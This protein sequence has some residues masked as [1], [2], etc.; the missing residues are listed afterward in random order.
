MCCL[1]EQCS[2]VESCHHIVKFFLLSGTR[3]TQVECNLFTVLM[4][5]ESVQRHT[6]FWETML[7]FRNVPNWTR[8]SRSCWCWNCEI[9]FFLLPARH[10]PL[11]S[12]LHQ[13][14]SCVSKHLRFQDKHRCVLFLKSS[15]SQVAAWLFCPWLLWFVATFK[16]FCFLRSASKWQMLL[17]QQQSNVMRCVLSG[18]VRCL[19]SCQLFSHFAPQQQAP[20]QEHQNQWM[21]SKKDWIFPR[22]FSENWQWHMVSCCCVS[23]CKADLSLFLFPPCTWFACCYAV[24]VAS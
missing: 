2:S 17:V 24:V 10:I 9:N 16:L 14:F 7:H 18:K 8:R 3:K 21:R 20:L 1:F 12:E 15:S 23:H 4:K 22:Q 11:I 5:S 13:T 19:C 6:C